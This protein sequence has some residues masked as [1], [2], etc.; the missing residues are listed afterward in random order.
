MHSFFKRQLKQ[1]FLRAS[2]ILF[3]KNPQEENKNKWISSMDYIACFVVLNIYYDLN[4]QGAENMT[5]S[6]LRGSKRRF[7][8]IPP[9]SNCCCEYEGK[10]KDVR[11]YVS[12]LRLSALVTNI[13]S[14]MLW[15]L[16]PQSLTECLNEQY[17]LFGL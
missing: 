9:S 11:S 1:F 13:L 7:L 5:T 12:V 17:S 2:F 14:H 15:L 10:A 3:K 16:F 6:H 8:R 4:Y